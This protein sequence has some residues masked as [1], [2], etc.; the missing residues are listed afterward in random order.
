MTDPTTNPRSNELLWLNCLC[1]T[2]Q[3]LAK[4]GE[5][6]SR[7]ALAGAVAKSLGAGPAQVRGWF[8]G[9]DRL[10]EYAAAPIDQGNVIDEED[11]GVEASRAVTRPVLEARVQARLDAV[12]AARTGTVDCLFC[13][14]VAPSQG[15]RKRPVAS[16]LG[17]LLISRRYY[18][19]ADCGVGL[20]PSEAAVG[21]DSGEHTPRLAEAITQLSTT[22]PYPMAVGLCRSMLGVEISV[23][24]AEHLVA[25]R[26]A[27]V[28]IA[29]SSE[30]HQLSPYDD[31]GVPRRIRRPAQ[32]V[33]K[34]PD[35]AYL[36]VDGVCAMVR[37]EDPDRAVPAEPGS[38]GGKGRRYDVDGREIKN[39]IMYTGD[40]VATE[41]SERGCLL[42]KTY[43]SQLGPWKIFASRVLPELL[44]QRFD[45]AR[46]CV[47]LGDGAEWIRSLCAWLP[48]AVLQILDLYHVKKRINEV[49]HAL[50]PDDELGRHRWRAVQY[51]RAED[52]RVDDLQFGLDEVQ[53]KGKKACELVDSLRTYIRNHRDCMDYPKY[54][55]MGL[56]VGSGAVESANF[57][58]TGN[59][60]KLQ[61]MRWSELG[62]ADMALL[63]ADL[64]NGRWR[65]TTQHMLAA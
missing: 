60:L 7:E 65:A 49:A 53:P 52:G 47:V 31:K 17:P 48:F 12:E 42:D 22:V 36:E 5:P 26:A 24:G 2:Y 11:R 34:A 38:R 1:A 10:A 33:A 30:A 29:A 51:D 50:Y 13:G 23:H 63:R 62:A 59:R 41:G 32:A 19:C 55:A 6:P 37:E 39:A 56:R 9:I 46:L 61:G 43:V 14:E 16:S 35:I 4:N 57:H 27:F 20:F 44:R 15:R 40:D 58:V 21:L 18:Y 25:R 54:R 3:R 64:F 28:S 8:A 45:Q